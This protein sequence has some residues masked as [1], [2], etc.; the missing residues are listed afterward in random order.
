MV[1]QGTNSIPNK[2]DDLQIIFIDFVSEI[3]I[4]YDENYLG[5]H[6]RQYLNKLLSFIKHENSEFEDIR[7]ELKENEF[8][9]FKLELRDHFWIKCFK[10]F[11]F[12]SRTIYEIGS[13][14]YLVI[15]E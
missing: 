15:L 9:E 14:S 3:S 8:I 13:T 7:I 5:F 11:K 2:K 6:Y 1:L 10:Y 12:N 4:T